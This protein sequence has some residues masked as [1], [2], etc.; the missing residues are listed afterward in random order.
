M[1][2]L[3]DGKGA[4]DTL[5]PVGEGMW[6]AAQGTKVQAGHRG[7]LAN[8]H[9]GG[10]VEGLKERAEI[11]LFDSS[12]IL[13]IQDS[14]FLTAAVDAVVLVVKAGSTSCRDLA[15][16]KAMLDGVGARV[17]GVVI[18]EM[19]ARALR[20]YYTQYYNAYVRP[21]G[22]KKKRRRGAVQA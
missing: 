4:V 10:F 11:V 1:K 17:V 21:R 22:A 19:P 20:S 8:A 15:R 18:N 2:A 6:L 5:A 16:A 3:H 7:M 12:P 9:L 13:L 14:L